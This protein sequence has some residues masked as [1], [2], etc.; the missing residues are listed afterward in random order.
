MTIMDWF[1]KHAPTI[2]TFIGAGGV[3]ATGVLAAKETPTAMRACTDAK[4]EN[5]RTQLS[6]LEL[7][8]AA[9]PAY[10]PAIGTGLATILC[11]FGANTLNQRQ[12][13]SLV[14]AYA[15]LEQTYRDYRSKVVSVCGKNTDK[16]IDR[17]IVE[18]KEDAEDD[19]PPWDEVQTFYIEHYGKFFETTMEQVFKAEY[20]LNRNFA[21]RGYVTLNEFFD[22]IGLH[23]TEDGDKVGWDD[24]SGQA[25][26]GYGWIEFDH[27]HYV[28]EDGLAVCAIDMPFAPHSL[29]EE[30]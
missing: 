21:L 1:R 5:R 18:E 24:Y 6:K 9:I 20:H 14:S 22:F 7:A 25:F 19:R 2:L 30:L 11:I 3:V 27:R 26:Y 4:V 13:A 15:M 16:F 10:L 17:A 29:F 28:T 12:Q 23:R 8:K